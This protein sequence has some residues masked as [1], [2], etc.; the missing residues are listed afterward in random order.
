M[1]Q[2]QRRGGEFTHQR[3]GVP[4]DCGQIGAVDGALRVGQRLLQAAVGVAEFDD[5]GIGIGAELFEI[6]LVEVPCDTIRRIDQLFARSSK[7]ARS[8]VSTRLRVLCNDARSRLNWLG[9]EG[10]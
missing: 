4:A 2:F 6:D 9:A 7:P 10:M 5:Q 3:R 1:T 8:R